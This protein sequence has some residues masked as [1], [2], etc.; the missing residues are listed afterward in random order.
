MNIKKEQCLTEKRYSEL[1]EEYSKCKKNALVRHALFNGTLNNI[2]KTGDN[3]RATDFIFSVEIPTM[4]A[5]NQKSSGRCWIFAA[6][7]V[8]REKIAK[9]LKI[10]DFELS[11][12]FVAFYDRLEKVNYSLEA[13]IELAGKE[14]D[15]RTLQHVINNAL[16]DGGQW[17]MF[18]NIIKKYG[19]V[20]KKAMP[21]TFQSSN[22]WLTTSLILAEVAKFAAKVHELYLNKEME[23]A[24]PLKD[25]LMAKVYNLL[26]SAHGLVPQSFDF[27]YKDEKNEYH[28]ERGFTP[29]SFFDKYIG[30]WIDEYVSVT[31]A[32]TKDKPFNTTFTVA[33][34]G[35]VIE[36]K[37]VTHLNVSIE[38]LTEL[39]K[40]QLKDKEVAWFG[41]DCGK[42]ADR[43]VGIWDIDS[44]DYQTP[45]GLDYDFSKEAGLDYLAS[46]MN[47]AM[48]LTGV[49]LDEQDKPVRWKV[50]NSWGTEKAFQG[51]YV[52]SQKWFEHFV[53]QVVINKKYLNEVELKALE[54]EPIVLKPWDPMGSLAD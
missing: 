29:K 33:Y 28:I 3:L 20:P 50:E 41:S 36:G 53:F 46:V 17:D 25:E 26:T 9:E 12:N 10:K 43:E 45:F 31:N 34:L 24:R 21:E 6:L 52:A 49:Q 7:N 1:S 37:K 22:T 38:R 39:T 16:C 15:D 35:N 54:K 2:A 42:Y 44:W 23:K 30:S 11:Q 5:T 13:I 40:T 27:E 48:V 51:Y 47:H 4:S 8:L 19:I 18:V 32:P 14:H